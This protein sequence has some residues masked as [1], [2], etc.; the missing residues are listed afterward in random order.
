MT[1]GI[2][3]VTALRDAQRQGTVTIIVGDDE[4][5]GE[6]VT[7]AADQRIAKEAMWHPF[8]LFE[9]EPWQVLSV[10]PEASLP[11]RHK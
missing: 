5:T 6:R 3:Y 8:A 1:N 2:R 7:F 9:V 4:R 10:R 11:A